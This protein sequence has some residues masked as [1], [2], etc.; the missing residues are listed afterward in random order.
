MHGLDQG[1]EGPMPMRVECYAARPHARLTFAPVR[2]HK[3]GHPR[4]PNAAR[5]DLIGT[6]AED[7]GWSHQPSA[8]YAIGLGT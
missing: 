4:H 1:R 8:T 3:V 7:E 5:P 6:S 2:E